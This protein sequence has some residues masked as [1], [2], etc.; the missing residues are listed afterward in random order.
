MIGKGAFIEGEDA[1]WI[2]LEDFIVV[3]LPGKR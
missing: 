3:P 2:G 1:G